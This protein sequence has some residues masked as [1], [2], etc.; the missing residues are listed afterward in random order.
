MRIGLIC[1]DYLN[2]N[3]DPDTQ[4][5]YVLEAERVGFELQSGFAAQ[6]LIGMDVIGAGD[7]RLNRD[8]TA[9]FQID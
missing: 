3:F 6:V 7:L 9:R 4:L 5:P 2:P 1:G 8:G